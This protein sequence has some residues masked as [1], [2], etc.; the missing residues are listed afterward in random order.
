MRTVDSIE[1]AA[2]ADR[3]FQAAA[4]I[5]RWPAILSHYRS[6]RFLERR[7]GG[8]TVEMAAWR[9]F[10]WLRYPTRWV[11]ELTLDR[12]TQEIRYRHIRGIT[13]GMEVVWRVGPGARGAAVTIV[14][15]WAGP[16]WPLVGRLAAELVIGPVFIHGIAA[17][18]LAGIK[19]F[20][21]GSA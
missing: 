9:P 3:V 20:A 4:D 6:V 13:R 18:T 10:G 1:I 16:A 19:R 11:S 7:P 15:D 2:S 21:E 12:G 8:G 17:R 5:E 14:H